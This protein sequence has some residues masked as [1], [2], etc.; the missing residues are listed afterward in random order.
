MYQLIT[1]FLIENI[2]QNKCLKSDK[3][4]KYDENKIQMTISILHREA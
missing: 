2:T 4:P 1:M 3:D